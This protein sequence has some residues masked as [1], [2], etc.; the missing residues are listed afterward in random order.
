MY[1][2]NGV[3]VINVQVGDCWLWILVISIFHRSLFSAMFIP[4]EECTPLHAGGISPPQGL[5]ASESI[6]AK[7]PNEKLPC[8]C[9][10]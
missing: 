4:H 3:V 7:T 10:S 5:G 1:N 2:N 8:K 9:I 6:S